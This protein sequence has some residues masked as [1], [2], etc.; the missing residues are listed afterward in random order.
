MPA[1][2]KQATS[3]GDSNRG[4]FGEL[5]FGLNAVTRALEKD[6]VRL[7][8]CTRDLTPARALQH[9]PVLCAFR[10]VPLCPLSMTSQS[11]AE[12]MGSSEIRTVICM[13]FKRVDSSSCDELVSLISSKCPKID[14]PWAP[15]KT[16]LPSINATVASQKPSET[17]IKNQRKAS[18][19]RLK[20]RK[21][22]HTAPIKPP[23]SQQKV[24]KASSSSNSSEKAPSAKINPKA[25]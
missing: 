6:E 5:V 11:F 12:L 10:S 1:R 13:A 23:K 18:L 19:A 22:E 9:L 20:V 8:V 16:S 4:V 25:S 17:S 2:S 14:I 7:V 3:S 24:A 21:I 15:S